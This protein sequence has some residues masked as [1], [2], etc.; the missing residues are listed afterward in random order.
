MV[1][2]DRRHSDLYEHTESAA[3][4]AVFFSFETARPYS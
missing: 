2:F 3:T 1:Q 4:A